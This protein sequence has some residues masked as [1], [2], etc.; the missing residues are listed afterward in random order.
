MDRSTHKEPIRAAVVGL[1]NMGTTHIRNLGAIDNVR[2]VAVCDVSSARVREAADSIGCAGYTDAHK[3]FEEAA[4][5]MVVISTPHYDHTPLAVAAFERGIHVL[6]EKPLAVEAGQARK[7]IEAFES[8]RRENPELQFGAM[9][10]QR[11]FG[12]WMKIKD[13]LDSGELGR[14]VRATWIITDWF[15]TQ[16]YYDTGDWRATWAGEGGGVLLNQCPHNL[17]LYQWFFGMPARVTGFASLGKYHEIEVE[18]EVTAYFE[19]ENGMIGHFITSTGESPGTNRLEIVGENGKLVFEEGVL[20]FQR[21]RDSML[22]V[23][24]TSSKSFTKAECWPTEIPYTHHGEPGHRIVTEKFVGAIRGGEQLVAD[25][26]EGILSVQL[27]NAIMLSSF[28]GHAV[29]MP[30]DEAAYLTLLKRLQRSS[31]YRGSHGNDDSLPED[32]S[33]SY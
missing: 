19:H 31:S 22:Q 3:L 16:H 9:F 5:D 23:L 25:A 15:R 17:D 27:G 11:T 18:D 1:G 8:A 32:L 13:L 20:S 21:N 12:Y 30:L 4:L 10:N 26:R 28:E 2:V 24:K 6:V 7:S 29:E 14:V 33:D